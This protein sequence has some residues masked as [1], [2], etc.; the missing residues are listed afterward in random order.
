MSRNSS[1]SMGWAANND[2]VT[3]IAE[4]LKSEKYWIK[5]PKKQPIVQGHIP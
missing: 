4:M 2:K 1:Y 5:I 3:V